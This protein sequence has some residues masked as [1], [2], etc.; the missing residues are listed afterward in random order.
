MVKKIA[1]ALNIVMPF[2]QQCPKWIQVL[3]TVGVVYAILVIVVIFIWF[4]FFRSPHKE[5]SNSL[6][7]YGRT[8]TPVSVPMVNLKPVLEIKVSPKKTLIIENKGFADLK[9]I[10]IFV[11]RY[12]FDET[13]FGKELKIKEY[14]KIGGSLYNIPMLEAKIGK[15]S[16]DLTKQSLIKFYDNPGKGDDSMPLITFYCFRVTYRDANTGMKYIKY[17]VTSSYKNYPSLIENREMT[18]SSGTPEGDFMYK[19]PKIIEDHQRTIFG[20]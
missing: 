15:E 14:N 18:A 12:V 3:V 13:C 11:T 1:A 7:N 4:L 8:H 2:L 5:T 6:D 9:D 10:S 20:E 16:F 17:N 19:I